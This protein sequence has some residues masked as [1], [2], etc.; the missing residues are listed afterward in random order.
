MGCSD[1]GQ[2]AGHLPNCRVGGFRAWSQSKLKVTDDDKRQS[3]YPTD[4]KGN[5]VPVGDLSEY[6]IALV[7]AKGDAKKVH[8]VNGHYYAGSKRRKGAIPDPPKKR[9]RRR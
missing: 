2:P 3:W 8:H 9:G 6:E 5:P 7:A 4:K 1:C